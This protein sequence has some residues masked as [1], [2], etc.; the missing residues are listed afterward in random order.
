MKQL[1]ALWAYQAAEIELEK[2][3]QALK[4]T[5]TRKRLIRQQQLFKKNQTHLRQI[6]QELV[7]TQN[8][9]GEISAQV[10][11]LRRQMQEKQVEI[12]EIEEYDLDDLFA[13]DVHE[14]TKECETIRT[15]LE[16]SKRKLSDIMKRLEGS[17]TDIT[18]TL[19]K[20]SR[21]K[22]SFDELKEL[23]AGELEAGKGDLDQKKQEVHAAAKRVPGALLAQYKEIK[24]HRANPVAHLVNKRC[25]GCNMEV[26]SGVLQEIRSGDRVVVCEN[27]GRI[28]LTIEEEGRT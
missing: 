14:L 16:A 15:S 23:H 27:C 4:N 13:D 11:A 9:L 1:E 22:K 3:E 21:A 10:E 12:Q 5:D 20:M 28:L 18:E 2:L 25:Q 17:E 8:A 26:P 24:Q 6:E 7:L 19:V